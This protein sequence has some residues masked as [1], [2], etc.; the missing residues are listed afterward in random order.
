MAYSYH[1]LL[2]INEVDYNEKDYTRR[3]KRNNRKA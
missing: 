1:I 2:F 3:I